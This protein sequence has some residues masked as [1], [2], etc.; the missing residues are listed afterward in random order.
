MLADFSVR[1]S[2]KFFVEVLNS[3]GLRWVMFVDVC[4][5]LRVQSAPTWLIRFV[6]RFVAGLSS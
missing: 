3:I 6:V 1:E 4:D 5:I 2:L